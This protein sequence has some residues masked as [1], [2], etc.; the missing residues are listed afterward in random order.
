MLLLENGDLVQDKI[1]SQV[2][3]SYPITNNNSNNTYSE[4]KASLQ[5]KHCPF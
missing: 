4:E 3:N 1:S 2:I 5:S